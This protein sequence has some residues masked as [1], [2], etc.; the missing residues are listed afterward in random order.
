MSDRSSAPQPNT[1][2]QDRPY[3]LSPRLL[4]QRRRRQRRYQRLVSQQ[5]SARKRRRYFVNSQRA[6]CRDLIQG[7]LVAHRRQFGVSHKSVQPGEGGA[8]REG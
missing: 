1:D 3:R 8:H 4:N 2:Q 7:E 6:Y 5:Q